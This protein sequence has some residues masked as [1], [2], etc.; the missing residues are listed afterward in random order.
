MFVTG[1]SRQSIDWIANNADGWI[2][3]PRDALL[4]QRIV[5]NWI[6]AVKKTGND[7]KPFAQSLYI[8]LTKDPDA[9]P[10][11]IHLGYRLGRNKLLKH[12]NILKDVGVN[13]VFFN[14]KYSKRPAKEVIEELGKYIVPHFPVL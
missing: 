8:D 5:N 7:F 3:Y 4:Q 12:L 1:H 10:D 14:L 13:H 9:N 6:Q 11:R 2:M